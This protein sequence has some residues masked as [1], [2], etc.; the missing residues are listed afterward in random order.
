MTAITRYK[1]RKLAKYTL[2]TTAVAMAFVLFSG[3]PLD[4]QL[5]AWALLGLWTGILEE[6][7]FGRR[8]RAL[9]IPLQFI[10][11]VLL[12]NLLTIALIAVAFGWGSERFVWFADDRPARVQE[13]FL[14]AQL[15]TLMLRVVVVT[16]IAILVVQMEEFM[17][18][19]M[20]VGFL[21]GRYE[22]PVAEERVVL[23]MDLVGSTGL[24]E[25]MGDMRYFR[26]LN[27]TYSLMTDAILRNEADIHKY[28]GDEVIFTWPMPIGVRYENC[29]DLYF[30]IQERIE[31]HK[32]EMKSEFGVV[33]HFRA[34]VHGGR[35]ISA[36]IG[37]T[38]RALEL[39]GDVMNSVARILGL[40][41]DMKADI[42]ISAELLARIPEA[43]QRFRPGPEEI[44]PV[45][46][47]K[48][49]VRVHTLARIQKA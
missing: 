48:R 17:G 27:Y 14:M 37:H 49:E 43:D 9:A 1:L 6:Y 40:A 15:Y 32:E 4:L 18:R 45:K 19:R 20:F 8:F 39:S 10:G 13:I 5:G 28:V 30:D 12:V 36:Q 35:V 34:A 24:A 22:R 41:K 2:V 31:L 16:S 38:K 26:F 44:L 23:T 3:E 11:K 21:L 46:G 29:L 47:R 7:M 25:R 33:P 42:L